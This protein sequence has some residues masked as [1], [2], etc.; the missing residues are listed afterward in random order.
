MIF[1]LH[2]S[3]FHQGIIRFHYVHYKVFHFYPVILSSCFQIYITQPVTLYKFILIF[4]LYIILWSTSKII[5]NFSIYLLA[6]TFHFKC[7]HFIQILSFFLYQYCNTVILKFFLFYSRPMYPFFTDFLSY[8]Y[9]S[10]TP[11]L[12]MIQ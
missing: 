9:I 10:S 2:F 11:L 6:S 7:V 3:Y 8:L 12:G 1:Y 4:F 5:K